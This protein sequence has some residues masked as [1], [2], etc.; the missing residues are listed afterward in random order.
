MIMRKSTAAFLALAIG[1]AALA[2]EAAHGIWRA[3]A[4]APRTARMAALTEALGLSDPALFTGARYTRHPS[5]ADLFSAFQD[6]PMAFEHFPAGSLIPPPR[7]FGP[8]GRIITEP[9]Q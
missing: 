8:S 2:A 1:L 6:A 7:A 3:A 5:Q 4:F 9:K